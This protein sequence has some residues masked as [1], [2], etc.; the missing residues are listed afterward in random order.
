M[1]DI[2]ELKKLPTHVKVDLIDQLLHSI[3]DNEDNGQEA[4]E[5]DADTE[6]IKEMVRRLEDMESG[7]DPGYTWEEAEAIWLNTIKNA[8]EVHG[9]I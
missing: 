8:R 5:S 9:Q 2:E 1:I 4:D 3:D 7:K 6:I